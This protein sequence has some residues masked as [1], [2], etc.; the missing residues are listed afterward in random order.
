MRTGQTFLAIDDEVLFWFDARFLGGPGDVEAADAEIG[1]LDVE[2]VGE[3]Y[4]AVFVHRDGH[5][6]WFCLLA[7]LKGVS[8]GDCETNLSSIG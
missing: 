2:V 6:G 1:V 3:A 5:V 8:R 4:G 7:G